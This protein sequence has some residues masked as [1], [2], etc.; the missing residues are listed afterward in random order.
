MELLF[1]VKSGLSFFVQSV[2]RV[3]C[4]PTRVTSASIPTTTPPPSNLTGANVGLQCPYLF[5]YLLVIAC[6][7]KAGQTQRH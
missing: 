7:L 2:L 4:G 5:H 6:Q 3:K 1:K